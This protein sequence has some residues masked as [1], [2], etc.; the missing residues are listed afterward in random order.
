VSVFDDMDRLHLI[1]ERD[2]AR[3]DNRLLRAAL[4][5]IG[6]GAGALTVEE[7]LYA[8]RLASSGETHD[9]ARV[10]ARFALAVNGEATEDAD[11]DHLI[12]PCP[13]VALE[14]NGHIEQID[15]GIA[16]LVEVL[17]RV[18][19][20]RTAWSCEGHPRSVDPRAWVSL[21]YEGVGFDIYVERDR[22]ADL[23]QLV[24]RIA[25]G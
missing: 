12:E 14:L 25:A 19:G 4:R 11:E 3:A 15:A 20:A 21:E 2:E 22:L 18:R 16:P 7:R 24:E 17:N 10:I 23:T 13:T 1:D 9:A 8:S 6:A 5:R